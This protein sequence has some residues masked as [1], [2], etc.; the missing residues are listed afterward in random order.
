VYWTDAVELRCRV[1]GTGAPVL[2]LHA[3]IADSRMWWP[4]FAGMPEGCRIVAPD[5]PP[6]WFLCAPA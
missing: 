1:S 4:Q 2:A 6:G 5:M 3:G